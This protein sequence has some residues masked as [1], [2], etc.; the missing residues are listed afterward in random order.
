MKFNMGEDAFACR[1]N[2]ENGFKVH[3]GTKKQR[4]KVTGS[5]GRRE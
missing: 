3:D 1:T 2:D 5:E 4:E